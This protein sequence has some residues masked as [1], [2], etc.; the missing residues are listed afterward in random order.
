MNTHK[1]RDGSLQ[2]YVAPVSL[3]A[4]PPNETEHCVPRAPLSPARP[5]SPALSD[6]P[7][8]GPKGI[9][10]LGAD[11]AASD[12]GRVALRSK[13]K[14][15]VEMEKMSRK[16]GAITAPT[17][18]N[19]GFKL[20]AGSMQSCMPDA[21]ENA[22]KMDGYEESNISSARMRTL[23][24]PKLGNVLQ[25]SWASC[26]AA[27]NTL[28]LPY[29]LVEATVRFQGGPPMLNLLRATEGVFVVA[30]LVEIEGK[31][32]DHCVAFSANLGTLLDNGSKT[33]PV[34]IEDKDRRGKKAARDA[35]RQLVSQKVP[36]GAHFSVDVTEIFEL[37]RI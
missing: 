11:D 25:A 16:R 37:R 17:R 26:K 23:A 28:A 7:G 1:G 30:L 19:E 33:K 22:M 6:A 18:T 29:E 32:N 8:G 3:R 12:D 14:M 2:P 15:E 9:V 4:D 10:A 21:I 13:R 27:L 35:F 36:T 20:T 5:D 24:I 31:K 34:Y